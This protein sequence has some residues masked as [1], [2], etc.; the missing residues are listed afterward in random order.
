MT[1][2]LSKAPLSPAASPM[3]AAMEQMLAQ[4]EQAQLPGSTLAQLP[5]DSRVDLDRL[6]P[7]AR[8]RVAE[9]ASRVSLDDTASLLSFG[10]DAQRRANAHLDRLMGDMSA[11]EAGEAGDLLIELSHGLSAINLPRLKRE[12]EGGDWVGSTL[13]R[14][15]LVGRFFSALRHFQLSHRRVVSLLERVESQS[16]ARRASLAAKHG[17]M[18]RLV[19]A[20]MENI[21]ELE[22]SLAAGVVATEKFRRQFETERERA[23]AQ[24]DPMAAARLRDLS[25]RCAAFET[26]LVRMHLA[27]ADALVSVPEIR[28]AQEAARI[29]MANIVD[30]LLFDLPRLKR[31]ILRVASLAEIGRARRGTQRQ[32]EA[33][34][35]I[36]ALG[37]DALAQAYA[38]AKMSQGEGIDE[39]AA[40]SLEAD[41]VLE[42][43]ALG[44]KLEQ[45]NQ[46]K[47]ES[48]HAALGALRSKLADGLRAHGD[49]IVLGQAPNVAL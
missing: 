11:R 21:G 33:A 37:A 40:L 9:L 6:A 49:Q 2:D 19:E 31:A 13:G 45:E 1:Q 26:R 28:L 47:R 27:Y 48:A 25:E 8:A 14:L 30:T 35:K 16:N 10:S 15:P 17:Q 3:S 20:T 29:E 36:G 46:R 32:R 24:R 4:M 22:L 43:M 7:A 44:L 34:R 5:V 12:T 39:V 18:D 38:N 42:T 41:K 23:R